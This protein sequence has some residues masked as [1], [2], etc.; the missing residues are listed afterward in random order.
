MPF[1]N[2][3][4]NSLSGSQVRLALVMLLFVSAPAFAQ[5]PAK[6]EAT[7]SS[8]GPTTAKTESPATIDTRDAR[9]LFDE[10][11]T[12][13]DKH[14]AELNKQKVP[15]DPKLAAKIR[16]E[17]KDLAIKYAAVLQA[18]QSLADPDIYY[19]GMLQH[20]A[21]NG[22]L[23]LNAMRRYL[24]T[25][26]S[27]ERAQTARA[28]LVLYATRKNLIAE[29]ERAVSAFAAN[30]PRDLTEWF[31]METLIT[32]ASMKEKDYQRMSAHA[33]E[34]I[35]VAKLVAAGKKHNSFRRD[36][37][38]FKGSSLFAEAQ[39]QLNNKAAA[40]ATISELR[41][42]ALTLPSGN[43]LR[44]ANIWLAAIDRSFNPRAIFNETELPPAGSLPEIVAHQWLDQTPVKLSE[45]RGQVV[46]LDFWAPWCGPCRHTFPKLQRWHETFKDKGLVILGL[47]N[48]SGNIEGRKATRGEELAYLRAF[49]K[50]NQLP[51]GFAV[52][53]T[54]TNDINY[55]VFSIPMSFLIDRRGNV[56]F[57]AM[58]ASEPEITALGKMIEKVVA[59]S[60]GDKPTTATSVN[61]DKIER[62]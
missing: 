57:I 12:Y 61:S 54:P 53:E 6:G 14:F 40:I 19:L 45:L 26:A 49:K 62:N 44:L 21:G 30:E 20:L 51:Y 55:G 1:K 23:A 60:D 33:K 10:A 31:G 22:D 18:R 25:E 34:M 24:E 47:T 27:G 29:A 28:V 56:R 37:M 50:T 36:E 52:S 38:L 13:V 9:V 17:Q 59:E 15:Y 32:E 3:R 2:Q 11:H 35:K 8:K 7:P 48:Y 43:L 58:G 41:K 5:T 42:M 39:L 16:Q 4:T 46:L